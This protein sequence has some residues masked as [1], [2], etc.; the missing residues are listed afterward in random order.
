MSQFKMIS[1]KS[2][3]LHHSLLQDTWRHKP[4][5]IFASENCWE[6]PVRCC[7]RTLSIMMSY[8]LDGWGEKLL[9]LDL[10][11]VYS[12]IWKTNLKSGA[13]FFSCQKEI[14]QCT[15]CKFI[16]SLTTHTSIFCIAVCCIPRFRSLFHMYWTFNQCFYWNQGPRKGV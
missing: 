4:S 6:E 14:F 5:G 13:A 15:D 9:S 10:H 7:S 11:A 16:L 1:A 12:K 3:A 2:V 8:M